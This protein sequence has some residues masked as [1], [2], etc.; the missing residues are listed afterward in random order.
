MGVKLVVC[1]KRKVIIF[2]RTIIKNRKNEG[3]GYKPYI[4][5]SRFNS[6]G[7]TTVVTDWKTGRGV[8]CLS[9]GEAL[10]YYVL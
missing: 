1:K 5:T 2:G 8:H 3:S 6:I 4:T 9:Q 10:W 7:T